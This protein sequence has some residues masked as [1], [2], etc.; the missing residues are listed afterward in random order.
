MKKLTELIEEYYRN[1]SME[2]LEKERQNL[3]FYLKITVFILIAVFLLLTASIQMN[4]NVFFLIFSVEISIF[5]LIYSLLTSGYRKKFKN[6]VVNSLVSV[7]SGDFEYIPTGKISPVKYDLSGLFLQHYDRYGGED[8]VRGVM[9]G[10]KF[11]FSDIHTEY[12]TTDS[13]GKT[14]WQTVFKGTF[15]VS[16]FNKK[17]KGRVLVYPDYSEKFL[18]SLANSFQKFY[19]HNL[20]FVKM[21]SPE[22]EKEFVV[23]S[24]DQILARYVLSTALMEKIMKFKKAIKKPIY[25]SFKNNMMFVAISGN[26][27][28]EAPVFRSLNDYGFAEEMIGGFYYISTLIK[29]LSIER[30]IW[31]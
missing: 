5:G 29:T 6:K 25:F 30:N 4:E 20:E 12:R 18:G 9:D 16:E 13:K 14:H 15:F 8:Y 17:F 19:S 21:D 24:N 2:S 10:V 1:P 23:Y 11:E 22:F 27:N 7:F 3:L 26:N 31:N 28:F